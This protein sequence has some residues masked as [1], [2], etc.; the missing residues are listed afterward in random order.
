[1]CKFKPEGLDYSQCNCKDNSTRRGLKCKHLWGIEFAIK[2]G[3]IKDIEELSIE[4][5]QQQYP[6]QQTSV[7]AAVVQSSKS[8]LDDEY[9]F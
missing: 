3:I 4:A 8:Y 2:W 9:D 7:V 5:R 1:L 6:P